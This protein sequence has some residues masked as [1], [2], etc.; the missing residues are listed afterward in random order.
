LS[1]PPRQRV[2][3]VV[4]GVIR[5]PEGRVLLAQ[6]P[7]GRH[8]AGGWEFPGGKLEDGEA[9]FAALQRELR[10]EVGIEVLTA[11]PLVRVRH[12]Y[13]EREI[14]LDVW[15][16]TGYR[17]DPVGREGQPLRWCPCEDLGQAGLLAADVPVIRALS[18]R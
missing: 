16:V 12:A 4:A 11:S 10:E 13:P 3:H 14:E 8:L 6:R 5:D 7:A 2:V 15:V 18:V 1:E 17:G 9:P